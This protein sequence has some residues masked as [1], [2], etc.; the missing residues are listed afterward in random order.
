MSV[1]EADDIFALRMNIEPNAAAYAS[2]VADDN[3][4]ATATAAFEQLDSAAGEPFAEVAIANRVFH[5]A[6]VRPG[7]RFLQP[8]RLSGWLSWPNAMSSRNCSE[9]GAG[10]ARTSNTANF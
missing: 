10:T 4:R 5:T 8:R 9:V 7:R 3:D 2:T 1:A 6:L